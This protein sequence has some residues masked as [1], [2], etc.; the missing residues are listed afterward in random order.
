MVNTLRFYWFNSPVFAMSINRLHSNIYFHR[1]ALHIYISQYQPVDGIYE[2]WRSL[3]VWMEAIRLTCL[4]EPLIVSWMVG[5]VAG[6]ALVIKTE[7]LMDE[8]CI[9]SCKTIMWPQIGE[10]DSGIPSCWTL[11]KNS[12]VQLFYL[13]WATSKSLTY[14][15]NTQDGNEKKSKYYLGQREIFIPEP[16]S[17]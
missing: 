9:L 12:P 11:F 10:C 15:A 1:M 3:V 14:W 13:T 5:W 8:I 7:I 16:Q 2:K 6:K 4:Q 17:F